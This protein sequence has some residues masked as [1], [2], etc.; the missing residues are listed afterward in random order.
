MNIGMAGLFWLFSASACTLQDTEPA[1]F[2]VAHPNE[3]GI[4]ALEVERETDEA[5]RF[6]EVR[7]LDAN[8]QT[9][10]FVRR[11]SGVINDLAAH[12]PG[13]D[14][15]GSEIV[16]STG[17]IEQRALSRELQVFTLSGGLDSEADA[18][19]AIDEVATTLRR[20]A[21]IDVAFPPSDNDVE[22]AL[23]TRNCPSSTLNT[24]PLAR[25]CCQ[26][27]NYAGLNGTYFVKDYPPVTRIDR[28]AN[29]YGT[30]CKASNGTSSCSGTDCY[31]GPNG[32]RRASV[33]IASPGTYWKTQT[34]SGYYCQM[35]NPSYIASSAFPSV[36][37]TH[38][39]GRGC[40]VNGSGPCGNGLIECTA[41]GGGGS[42]G[43][44]AWD[45]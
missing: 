42:A 1:R 39:T 13:P 8:D 43:R 4:A 38:P 44:F 16:I 35:A 45:Y 9:V 3:L 33:F 31:Y 37:G 22:T 18:F 14:V 15:T 40:C 26:T 27:Y 41:C 24:Q 36:T 11:R 17:G 21:G 10:A 23:S 20:E 7:G 5:V 28:L 12:L 34:K 32:H 29:P 30:A 2:S 6:V 19:L 25:M